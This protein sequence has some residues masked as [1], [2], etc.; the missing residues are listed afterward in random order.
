MLEKHVLLTMLKAVVLLNIF[1][2]TIIS[3]YQ[4]CFKVQKNGIYCKK[5]FL[6]SLLETKS[7]NE[8]FTATVFTSF[9]VK[10]ELMTK[11]LYCTIHFVIFSAFLIFIY[12]FLF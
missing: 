8:D 2:K 9:Q 4:D 3:F 5:K 12:T 10:V 6:L 11:V 7:L 1:V